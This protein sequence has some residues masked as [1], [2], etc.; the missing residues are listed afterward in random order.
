MVIRRARRGQGEK[1]V[2]EWKE[3]HQ[4][5]EAMTHTTIETLEMI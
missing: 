1:A 4:P 2:S 5:M 3:R